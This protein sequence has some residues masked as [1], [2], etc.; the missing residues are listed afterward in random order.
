MEV[1]EVERGQEI[2]KN[3]TSLK[4]LAKA[5]IDTSGSSD[6]HIDEFTAQLHPAYLRH[7]SNYN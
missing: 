6:K 7:R 4:E 3:I 2:R 1:L 5:A